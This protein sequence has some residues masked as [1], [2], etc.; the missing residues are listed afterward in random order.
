MGFNYALSQSL[1]KQYDRID[2]NIKDIYRE[3]ELNPD[4]SNATK[5]KIHQCLSKISTLQTEIKAKFEAKLPA[6]GEDPL[7]NKELHKK[8]NY[9]LGKLQVKADE[10]NSIPLETLPRQIF[11]PIMDYVGP[12]S[13]LRCVSHKMSKK[14]ETAKFTADFLLEQ[15]YSGKLQKAEWFAKK[16]LFPFN[17]FSHSQKSPAEQDNLPIR[18]AAK[19][20]HTKMVKLLLKDSRVDPTAKE[21]MALKNAVR[22]GHLE[23]VKRLL[24]D[25][26]IVPTV[27]CVDLAAESGHLEIVK[28]FLADPRI[29]PTAD[30]VNGAAENGHLEIVK[31]LLAD[32]R[33]VPT[34]DCINVAAKSGHLEIVKLLLTDLRITPNDITINIALIERKLEVVKLLLTD[35]RITPNVTNINVSLK[36]G[37]LEIVKLLL[38]HK[39]MS[40]SFKNRSLCFAAENGHTEHVRILLEHQKV[41]PSADTSEALLEATRNGHTEIV[42]LL[43]RR[44]SANY[45][46]ALI[47][48]AMYNHKEIVKLI[49]ENPYINPTALFQ[50]IRTA[51]HMKLIEI[52]KLL[53]NHPNVDPLTVDQA[54]DE[55][56][57]DGDVEILKILL[58]KTDF[59]VSVLTHAIKDATT[60]G[61]LA[62]VKLLLEDPRI[63]LNTPLLNSRDAELSKP[64]IYST[65]LIT[66]ACYGHVE[67]VELLLKDPRIDPLTT[68]IANYLFGTPN[69]ST[70][71]LNQVL[72]FSN[73][74]PKP[75]EDKYLEIIKVLLKD[76]KVCPDSKSIERLVSLSNA[77]ITFLLEKN[78]AAQNKPLNHLLMT[79]TD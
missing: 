35:P 70:E 20:G 26:R 56:Q 2:D 66:A 78:L 47:I 17:F 15:L 34:A 18:W 4:L 24:A 63:G 6:L 29:I 42:R 49:L 77:E 79:L 31:L 68:K 28:L 38:E 32:S 76:P 7:F 53:L 21:N 51:K 75:I 13:A 22:N 8:I 1:R 48:A 72:F 39:G 44:P 73:G 50:A 19:N 45:N 69:N 33:I 23:I 12:S 36:E 27:L 52:Q 46:N 74:T 41:E 5:E 54:I 9:S 40:Q 67:I 11:Q 25:L 43:L 61:Q 71:A 62:I 58:K 65:L 57:K 3:S 10:L 64:R 30:C 16:H 14:Y 37:Y 60:K 55:A 59:N